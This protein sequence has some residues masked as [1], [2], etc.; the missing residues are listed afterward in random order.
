MA[1][2][3]DTGNVL[4]QLQNA[5]RNLDAA[6]VDPHDEQAVD[7]FVADRYDQHPS[8]AQMRILESESITQRERDAIADFVDHREH[9]EDRAETTLISDLGNLRRAAAWSDTELVEMDMRD[10]RSLLR[11]LFAPSDR[12][13][14]GL[15]PDGTAAFGY[16]RTLRLFF[17]FLNDEPT[18]DEFDFAERIELPDVSPESTDVSDEKML[19][20][21]DIAALKE[22]AYG[23]RDPVLIEFLADVGGRISLVSQ[24]R[25]G[26][27]YD[28]ETDRPYFVPNESGLAQ[29]SVPVDQYPIMNSR[30]ELRVYLN[31]YHIDR[32]DDA[33][34]WPVDQRHYDHDDP[35]SGA[36]SGDR[37][38]DMLNECASRAGIERT[39]HPHMFRH[40]AATRLSSSD[41]LTPQEIVHVMGWSD[42][43]MLE[44]YD[45]TTAAERNE[46]IHHA[47]G[48]ADEPD[49]SDTPRSKPVPC[50][51]CHTALSPDERYCPN[52]GTAT[53]LG[54]RED[55]T[56]LRSSIF[57]RAISETDEE[58][59]TLLRDLNTALDNDPETRRL[60]ADVLSE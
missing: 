57:D 28:I 36:V 4:G 41:R 1:D 22:A 54:A 13:G 32:R 51:N 47:L 43:R 50:T 42:D 15:D 35:S 40:T 53:S 31:R 12:G 14:R 44:I 6:T 17:R 21:D 46:G 33:P 25:Y 24:L 8:S 55:M 37:I 10:I 29:K 58:V 45:E 59:V 19:S 11:H 3:N 27:I 60:V 30:A 48:F 26:D 2:V 49:D 7:A 38:R 18:Y 56:E 39:V 16:K 20:T 23:T 9:V 52:C 34:L 5:W